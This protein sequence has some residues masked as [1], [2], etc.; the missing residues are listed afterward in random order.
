[1][2][3][4]AGAVMGFIFIMLA[5]YLFVT[6]VLPF[7]LLLGLIA[8]LLGL[9]ALCIWIAYRLWKKR[10]AI[11]RWYYFSFHPHPAEPLVR[12]SLSGGQLLDGMRLAAMLGELP[13]DNRILREVRIEQ[14]EQLVHD[15]RRATERIIQENLAKARSDRER[16]AFIGIQESIALAA[17]ALERAKA[18]DAAS[19]S[20]R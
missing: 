8:L 10:E 2:D 12:T 4:L 5:V 17:V 6:Y 16:A 15:M 9:V 11:A 20:V 3:E 1:M 19:K 7:L 18:A 14:G 13:P